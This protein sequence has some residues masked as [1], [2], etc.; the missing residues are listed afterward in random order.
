MC[1]RACVC[2]RVCL[3]VNR[4]ACVCCLPPRSQQ[5]TGNRKWKD[6]HGESSRVQTEPAKT[7]D[8]LDMSRPFPFSSLILHVGQ[9][10]PLG[11]V[12]QYN[13]IYGLLKFLPLQSIIHAWPKAMGESKRWIFIGRNPD[14]KDFLNTN[15]YPKY[16]HL[17]PWWQTQFDFNYLHSKIYFIL[18]LLTNYLLDFKMN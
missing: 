10:F 1:V 14:W 16:F 3:Y 18:V 6:W 9:S 17:N 11:D 13:T 4:F 2:L 7:E 15:L 5:Q 12:G 8:N